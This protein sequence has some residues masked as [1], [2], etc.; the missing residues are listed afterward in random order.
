[1]PG[2]IAIAVP[3]N[4]LQGRLMATLSI[5]APLMRCSSQDLIGYLP[6]LR[7]GAQALTELQSQ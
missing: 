1:M 6:V 2:M 5:H 7:D 4:D 3:V